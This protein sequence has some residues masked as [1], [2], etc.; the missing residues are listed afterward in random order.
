M[1]PQSKRWRSLFD[2]C[3]ECRAPV[4]LFDAAV[5]KLHCE[6][7]LP[8]LDLAAL[9]LNPRTAGEVSLDGLLVVYAE[10]LLALRKVDASHILAA[11]YKYSRD[12]PLPAADAE[13]E[14]IAPRWVN[15]PE[16]QDALFERLCR[17]LQAGTRP[18]SISEAFQAVTVVTS[19]MSAMVAAHTSESVIHAMA[20]IQHHPQQ[21]SISNRDSLGILL[22]ALIENAKVA[23]LLRR[24]K[25]KDARKALSQALSS[26]IPFI[27]QT[28]PAVA[29][30]LEMLQKEHD[31]HDKSIAHL[32]GVAGSSAALDVAALQLNA[33]MDLPSI[34]TRAGLYVF[35]NALLVGRPLTDDYTIINHLHARYKNEPQIMMTALIT[36]AFDVLANASYRG[37]STQAMF[38]YKNFLINR[39]PVLLVQLA[40]SIY[41][42]T[43]EICITQALSQI[44][45]NA[46]PPFSQGFE[47]M[48]GGNNPLSDTRLD[49]LNACALHGLI[50][51]NTIERLLGEAPMQGPP[52]SRYGKKQLLAQFKDK[53]ESVNPYI[54]ELTALDGNAGAIAGAITEFLAHL[55]DAQMTMELKTICNLLSRKPE[56]LDV[57]L[58]FTTPAR[59]LRPL[60]QFLDEWRYEESQGEHQPVY[61]EF[62]SIFVLVLA[63]IHRYELTENDLAIGRESFVAQLL[64]RGHRSIP[65]GELTEDQG[66]VLE[67]WLRGLY[68]SDKEA[69]GNEVFASGRPQDFYFIVPT[70]FHQTVMACSAEVLSLDTV[71]NGL[72]Y[73]QDTF[74]LPSLVGGLSWMASHALEQTH[75]DIEVMIQIFHKLVRSAPASG[76]A[77]AMHSTVLSIV[78]GRLEKCF[79]TLKQRYPNRT[80]I[81]LLLQA[82]QPHVGYERSAYPQVSALH[83]WSS[84]PSNTLHAGIRQVVQ[85]LSHWMTAATVLQVPQTVPGYTHRLIYASL[86]ILG[87]HSTLR[88]ILE[89]VKA[90][91]AAGNGEAALDVAT[92]I[93]CAPTL[94]NSVLNTD[95]TSAAPMRTRLNLR[96]MLKVSFDNA[97]TLVPTEPILAETIVRLHRRV[98]AHIVAVADASLATAQLDMAN[99]GIADIPQDAAAL[100]KVLEEAAAVA[101][102]SSAMQAN[103]QAFQS[104]GQHPLDLSSGAMD[105][106][107]GAPN[108]GLAPDMGGLT[109]LDLGDMGLGMDLGDDDNWGLDLSGM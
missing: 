56:N 26:F 9:L 55:C 38:S 70:L 2:A 17:A 57:L 74:L 61:D 69:L 24:D 97:A 28:S 51:T 100:D 76:D 79:S 80:D 43:A 98:E 91:T 52:S 67:S 105:L 20:G 41:T 11:A 22:V 71:K 33:V 5:T 58:Q 44:D 103:Q 83:K 63:F 35:L 90:Q 36:A 21:S 23:E 12:R 40:A 87:V 59:L 47:D 54:N 93:I 81:D 109:D 46:F 65:Q 64:Q 106:G 84:A 50:A 16:L 6:S 7:P 96:E 92:S 108:P 77:L 99:V 60:C 72:E 68:D 75:Q 15:S 18:L 48:L 42:T 73:L 30:R 101:A 45:A 104:N 25:A 66:K 34:N 49:F 1:D 95:I 31:L 19:W 85:Q 102:A 14:D 10:R 82:I 3:L 78:S 32:N 86:R 8:G 13:A 89:E 53:F 27:T 62:G 107:I 39:V 37:E 4:D 29:T 94:S 88:A